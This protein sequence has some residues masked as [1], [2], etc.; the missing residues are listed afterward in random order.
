M[1]IHE[2]DN[3]KGSLPLESL[4]VLDLSRV[5]SGPYCSMMLGD[6]GATIWKVEPPTGDDSRGL[7]PPF[8]QGESAYYLSVNRNKLDICLDITRVEG[9]EVLLRMADKAD[10]LLENFR[11]DLK[12]RLGIGYQ[13]LSQRNPR[14]VYCSISGFGQDGPYRELPG[15]DNIFQGMA[16]LMQITG[17]EGEPPM[18][19]GER[20]ADVITGMQAAFGIMVALHDRSKSGRGQFLDLS[21]LD[22]LIACQAPMISYYF[23]TGSQPPKRGNGSLFSAPTETFQTADRPINPC[24][25]ID[26]HWTKLC[27]VLGLEKALDDPRFRN[28]PS[29]AENAEAVNGLVGT[30]L[31][32]KPASYWIEQMRS[33]GIP[34]GYIYTY[35]EMFHDPQV[36]HNQMLREIKHP[37]IGIQKTIGIPIR[38]HKTPGKIRQPAPLLGQHSREIL[39]E[40]AYT[41]LEMD[42]LIRQGI[43]I[44]ARLPD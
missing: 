38:L 24:I 15:L 5:L 39:Q 28:N 10:V 13:E 12:E 26:K 44:Q 18:K 6:M 32:S 35:D 37:T 16:G 34:C 23:A 43:V 3:E 33:A 11:P 20:I 2:R 7:A 17:V 36:I 14:L 9:R 21:L 29:R 42:L 25:F 1:N 22:S 31:R 19:V 41:D 27:R 4:I 8:I 40:L 30:V